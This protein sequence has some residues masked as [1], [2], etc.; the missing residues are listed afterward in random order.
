MDTRKIGTVVLGV[1][2]ITGAFTSA[3]MGGGG[4][5]EIT[6]ETGPPY[7][8]KVRGE[9]KGHKLNGSVLLEYNNRSSY[10]ETV[11]A[12]ILPPPGG[13]D[14]EPINCLSDPDPSGIC[15]RAPVDETDNNVLT[16]I[17]DVRVVARLRWGK[18]TEIFFGEAI[19][20][21]LSQD[22]SDI[23]DVVEGAIKCQVLETFFNNNDCNSMDMSLRNVT[24]WGAIYDGLETELSGAPSVCASSPTMENGCA[25]LDCQGSEFILADV[26]VA[27]H[28]P[29]SEVP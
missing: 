10:Y 14:P 2:L 5:G 13:G 7:G 22:V 18:Q 26:E 23:Q 21:D 20:V 12:V 27:V 6:G 29:L 16:R 24:E 9:A 15:C 4:S 28:E 3:A 17:V 19:G 11:K 1:L 25:Q 8:L